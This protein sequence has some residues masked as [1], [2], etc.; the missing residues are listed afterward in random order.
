MTV[1][2]TMAATVMAK[3]MIHKVQRRLPVSFVDSEGDDGYRSKE[4]EVEVGHRHGETV[5]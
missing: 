3:V 1:A 5:D 2:I 4:N